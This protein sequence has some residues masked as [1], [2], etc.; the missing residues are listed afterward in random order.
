MVFFC[1]AAN[2]NGKLKPE[3]MNCD[4]LLLTLET[5]NR[6]VP[7]FTIVRDVVLAVPTSTSPYHKAC[8]LHDSSAD[9]YTGSAA[10]ASR[11]LTVKKNNPL[12]AMGENRMAT[13]SKLL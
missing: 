10:S 2:V 11:A 13:V 12:A 4:A 5:V 7:L 3:G 6:V 8:G 1:P 9:A